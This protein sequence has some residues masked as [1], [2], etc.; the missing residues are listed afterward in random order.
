MA[1]QA[2]MDVVTW[3]RLSGEQ[4][5][6]RGKAGQPSEMENEEETQVSVCPSS[7]QAALS[8]RQ[9]E[10]LE[11]LQ[12][13]GSCAVLGSGVGMEGLQADRE[14]ICWTQE[15]GRHRVTGVI[16]GPPPPCW[17]TAPLV[18]GPGLSYAVDMPVPDLAPRRS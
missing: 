3:E 13:Q 2:S 9:Q 10:L 16:A 12:G 5:C 17:G 7:G 8:L 1:G 6:R 18:L 11:G 14:G 4:G 15:Q